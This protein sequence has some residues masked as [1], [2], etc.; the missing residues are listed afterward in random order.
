[1]NYPGIRSKLSCTKPPWT[2]GIHDNKT[3]YKALVELDC[4]PAQSH[5]LGIQLSWHVSGSHCSTLAG[6]PESFDMGKYSSTAFCRI[7]LLDAVRGSSSPSCRTRNKV[8]TIYAGNVGARCFLRYWRCGANEPSQPISAN[9]TATSK[10]TR[11][12]TRLLL[13]AS[14]TGRIQPSDIKGRSLRVCST[15]RI[16]TL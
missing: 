13:L 7:N 16:G 11:A 6:N 9:G 4:K 8:G 1:M 12:A 15:L 3:T 2:S 5:A 14:G 10:R